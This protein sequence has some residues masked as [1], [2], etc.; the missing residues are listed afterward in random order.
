MPCTRRQVVAPVQHP[1]L[2]C[3]PHPPVG[4]QLDTD[5]HTESPT[6]TLQQHT[7]RVAGLQPLLRPQRLDSSAWQLLGL[8][9]HIPS[10]RS[11]LPALWGR[12][13]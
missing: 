1:P 13:L 4:K 2:R 3:S 8:V 9:E 10:G 5:A 7:L 6:R 11:A 12:V